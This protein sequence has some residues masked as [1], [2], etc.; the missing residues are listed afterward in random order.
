ML[1]HFC[2]VFFGIYYHFHYFFSPQVVRKKEI[3]HNREL[4]L[5]NKENQGGGQQERPGR[6]GPQGGRALLRRQVPN[7]TGQKQGRRIHHIFY[8]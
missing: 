6:Q 2:L 5:D 1:K 7:L 3:R 8:S 4:A